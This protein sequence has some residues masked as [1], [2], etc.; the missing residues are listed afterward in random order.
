MSRYLVRF[1]PMEPYFFGNERGL[2]YPGSASQYQNL[3]FVRGENMPLQTT[4]LGALRF[5]VL[6]KYGRK[7]DE[8][9]EIK[10]QEKKIGLSSF[11]PEKKAEQGFG[12]IHKLSPVFLTDAAGIHYIPAPM[13]HNLADE[14]K[15]TDDFISYSPFRN[16]KTI[17]TADGQ[18]LYTE[19]YDLKK[20]VVSGFM[21]LADGGIH[22]DLFSGTIRV[23]INRKNQKNGFVKKEYK[24]LKNDFS[25]AV[26]CDLDGEWENMPAT[27]FL[28]QGHSTFRVQP[29]KADD[30]PGI[31]RETLDFFHRNHPLFAEGTAYTLLYCLGDSFM[32][33]AKEDD[34]SGLYD[35]LLFAVTDVRDFRSMQTKADGGSL[36]R[37]KQTT[38]YHL[39]KAGSVLIAEND[40]KARKWLDRYKHKNATN[41]GFNTFVGIDE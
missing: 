9:G 13:D 22:E 30:H 24:R 40:D 39:M 3:Y 5:M 14:A 38:L 32:L 31:E 29:Q 15:N 25:F 2:N 4:L 35:G 26:Y 10:D 21:S 8:F 37:N 7:P 1:T 23:G 20:G 19:E 16:Y 18:K 28:G 12:V 33:P 36:T 11:D 17:T 27:V 6:Q 34:V 41:I